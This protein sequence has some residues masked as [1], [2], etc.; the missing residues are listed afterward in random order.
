MKKL[1][2]FGVVIL[3]CV[4]L[5]GIVYKVSN[6]DNIEETI[7]DEN[8]SGNESSDENADEE[9]PY[10]PTEE[11]SKNFIG[12]GKI[13]SLDQLPHNLWPDVTFAPDATLI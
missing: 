3:T 4:A 5:L 1:I 8:T 13:E 12:E 9:P 2:F 7:V 6:K 11:E 10:I